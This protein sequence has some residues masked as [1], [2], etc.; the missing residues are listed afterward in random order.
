[1]KTTLQS[2]DGSVLVVAMML[3]LGMAVAVASYFTLTANS[4]KLSN[5]SY[6]A[7][8]TMNVAEAGLEEAMFAVNKY[9]RSSAVDKTIWT[10]KTDGTSTNLTAT[11]DKFDFGKNTFGKCNVLIKDYKTD[12]PVIVAHSIVTLT[13]GPAMEKWVKVTLDTRS[14]AGDGSRT[15]DLTEFKGKG[16]SNT[17]GSGKNSSGSGSETN[18]KVDSWDSKPTAYGKL[19][20]PYDS[21]KASD[22]VLIASMAVVSDAVD[23]QNADIYGRVAVGGATFSAKDAVGPQGSITGADTP[24]GTTV[25]MSRISYYF[26]ASFEEPAVPTV[27]TTVGA[28][29][30][31]NGT[32]IKLPSGL[33]PAYTNGTTYYYKA[34]AI[35]ITGGGLEIEP[36]TT[37]VIVVAD[38]GG[39][40]VTGQ[41]SIQLLSGSTA[42]QPDARLQIYTSGDVTLSG[43]GVLNGTASDTSTGLKSSEIQL[44]SNFRLFGT[45]K[46]ADGDPKTTEQKITL[47]GN[48]AFSGVVYAPNAAVTVNGNSDL[49]G[50]FVA[51]T[52]TFVGN[53][54]F[55]RD[56]SLD[57][58]PE[59]SSFGIA[60]WRELITAEERK[61]YASL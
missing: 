32:T 46:D 7:T 23:V 56:E 58:D 28:I 17:S 61:D 50:A 51:D 34:S 40:S 49:F 38:G 1:M 22:N 59:L 20:N 31:Q 21:T 11:F 12:E 5:R 36:G 10:E 14:I 4:L 26:K 53:G 2:R 37:V 30:T 55:H 3:T 18:A 54:K 48:G 15:K 13:E 24:S 6:Y 16:T 60:E 39:V 27:N 43:N 57:R 35:N 52:M 8:A 33:A 41:G 47:S 25:D 9:R 45:A 19:T 42:T 44:P 29:T